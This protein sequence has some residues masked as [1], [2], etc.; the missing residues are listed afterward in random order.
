MSR[1]TE[2]GDFGCPPLEEAVLMGTARPNWED[3]GDGKTATGSRVLLSSGEGDMSG[4][5]SW[6]DINLTCRREGRLP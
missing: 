6:N 5:D 4:T 3:R 1:R 2:V